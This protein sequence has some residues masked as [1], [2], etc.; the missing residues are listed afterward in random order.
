MGRP[1]RN[2]AKQIAQA[3][4]LEME[5]QEE[6]RLERERVSQNL[7]AEDAILERYKQE[8]PELYKTV[9]D[10]KDLNRISDID[11]YYRVKTKPSNPIRNPYTEG[12]PGNVVVDG[13]TYNLID[14]IENPSLITTDTP[15]EVI[16]AKN[17]LHPER[18]VLEKI[19][20]ARGIYESKASMTDDALLSGIM[21]DLAQQ[22]GGTPVIDLSPERRADDPELINALERQGFIEKQKGID[23]LG[24]AGARSKELKDRID[25]GTYFQVRDNII[26]DMDRGYNARTGAPFGSPF[27]DGNGNLVRDQL[28]GGH[29]LEHALNPEGRH[30]PS[31][32]IAELRT[33]NQLKKERGRGTNISD[34]DIFIQ[35]V[36]AAAPVKDFSNFINELKVLAAYKPEMAPRIKQL[37]KRAG[38][39]F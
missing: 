35:Q 27:L 5:L 13:K 31:N 19:P 24:Y 32:I 15:V 36:K 6:L 34:E 39:P 1:K 25:A 9:L 23:R 38:L 2:K 14:Y 26:G 29:I 17:A 7:I 12:A 28:E 11:D 20:Q 8:D 33:E 10:F 22:R 37:F 30:D 21:S 16:K 18:L 3:R 4:R